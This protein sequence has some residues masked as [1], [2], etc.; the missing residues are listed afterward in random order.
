MQIYNILILFLKLKAYLF[1]KKKTELY[2]I[3]CGCLKLAFVSLLYLFVKLYILQMML[4]II[5]CRYILPK[6]SIE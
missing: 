3:D 2:N 6:C 1:N 4:G 5:C